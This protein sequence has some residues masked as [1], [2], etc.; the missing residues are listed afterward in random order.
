M[1][2]GIKQSQN[3][4]FWDCFIFQCRQIPFYSMVR[5]YPVSLLANVIHSSC[6]LQY[7]FCLSEINLVL[8]KLVGLAFSFT[9]HTCISGYF[10]GFQCS[11]NLYGILYFYS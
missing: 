2:H 3:L 7:S 4:M 10:H 9:G 8:K 1:L 11:I 5:I 6:L